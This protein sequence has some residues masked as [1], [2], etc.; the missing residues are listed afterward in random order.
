MLS[1]IRKD[2]GFLQTP[3]THFCLILRVSCVLDFSHMTKCMPLLEGR[4]H[5]ADKLKSYFCTWEGIV[6]YF[7]IILTYSSAL[8][9]YTII[10]IPLYNIYS[11]YIEI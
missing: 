6:K 5:M 2:V 1:F 7:Y 10:I 3:G 4:H 11:T 8:N 9:E